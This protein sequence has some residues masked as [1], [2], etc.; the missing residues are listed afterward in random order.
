MGASRRTRRGSSPL[1][2]ARLEEDDEDDDANNEIEKRVSLLRRV[3]LTRR[4][5]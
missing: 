1:S 2:S 4:G 5:R 3:E